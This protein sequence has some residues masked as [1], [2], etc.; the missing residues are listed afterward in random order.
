M[1]GNDTHFDGQ[2]ATSI[3]TR[4]ETVSHRCRHPEMPGQRATSIKT[5]IE[6]S[7]N[8]PY[9]NLN[10]SQRATSIKTRIETLLNLVFWVNQF[11]SESNIH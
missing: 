2:R 1:V 5:R 10:G 9:P 7:F 3:K 8:E 6:T 4:I 11:P